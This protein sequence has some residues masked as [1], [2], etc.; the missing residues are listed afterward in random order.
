MPTPRERR[1]QTDYQKLQ[2]LAAESGGT[3]RI[4]RVKGAPPTLYELEY[5]CPGLAREGGRVVVRGDHRVEIRLDLSYPF[6]K[7]AA[8][9]LTPVFNPHVFTTR[10]VCL[11]VRW[12]PLETLDALVLRIGAILQL[13]PRVLDFK[14]LANGEAGAWA[15]AHPDQIPLPGAVSFKAPRPG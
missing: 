2:Q 1:L 10:A 11:G 15:R 12:T 4:V 5:R 3:I 7:P 6:S 13:D 14:S 9:V 8:R